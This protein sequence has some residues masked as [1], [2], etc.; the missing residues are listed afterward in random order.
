MNKESIPLR[1]I[2]DVSQINAARTAGLRYFNDQVPGLRRKRVGKGFAYYTPDNK[3][4]RD[5]ET[6]RR[7]KALA[8]PPAWTD[9]WICPHANGHIQATGR[10]S[11]GRK[12]Y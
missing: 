2:S 7:I 10:D 5:Q 4:V 8:I 11:K 9:V 6:L 12:Q 3:L 1:S